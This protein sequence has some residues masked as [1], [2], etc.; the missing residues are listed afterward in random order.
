MEVD[1]GKTAADYRTH[2]AGFPES[3]FEEVGARVV[4]PE[5]ARILDLGTGTG[6]LAR[7]WAFR[8]FRVSGRDIS[9]SMMAEARALDEVAGVDISYSVG[10]AEDTGFDD[11]TFDM[12]TAGQCWHWFDRAA[13]AR[14]AFR[15]VKPGGWLVIGTFDWLPLPGNVVEATEQLILKHNPE[16]PYAGG[17]GLH[18]RYIRETTAAGFENFCTFSYDVP[19]PYS[20]EAWR[21]RI[22]ASAGVAATLSP[23]RVEV[24]DQEHAAMLRERF[25][26]E[27]LSVPHR[28][29]ALIGQRP[30]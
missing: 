1:F 29:F 6:T 7:G 27:P 17:I 10:R 25:P 24:F 5:D 18:S 23:E 19:A 26:E 14:E 30:G 12:V 9:E 15:I 4:L 8:G 13:A 28:V 16:W 11:E 2:R 21:G 22:R 20:H 3:F